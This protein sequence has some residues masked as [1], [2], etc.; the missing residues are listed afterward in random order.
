MVSSEG[1]STGVRRTTPMERAKEKEME[2]KE[3]M[4]AKRNTEVTDNKEVEEHHRA[5]GRF[6]TL[7]TSVERKRGEHKGE[8]A[9][10]VWHE[11]R[12]DQRIVKWIHCSDDEQEGQEETAEER[13]E[14]K[15]RE[16]ERLR[17]ESDESAKRT[18]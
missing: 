6:R 15:V 1:E 12:K 5:R 11:P 8:E 7:R 17:K 4:K 16:E 13:E 14:R 3:N 2:E 9:E 18:R 10:G